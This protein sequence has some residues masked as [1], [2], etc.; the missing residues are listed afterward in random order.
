LKCVFKNVFAPLGI[1]K[2]VFKRNEWIVCSKKTWVTHTH[3]LEN[4][5]EIPSGANTFLKTH[6]KFLHPKDSTIYFSKY[7]FKWM[8][9]LK[10]ILKL[11]Y[12]FKLGWA[13]LWYVM[14]GAY[15]QL[16]LDNLFSKWKIPRN[17]SMYC[18]ECK[19]ELT[20]VL[21]SGF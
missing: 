12:N 20:C 16:F 1:F 10:I 14:Q 9:I 4:S 15:P 21:K 8:K 13:Q 18:R 5:G 2:E 17:R 7:F 19:Q 6:F 3:N 11:N